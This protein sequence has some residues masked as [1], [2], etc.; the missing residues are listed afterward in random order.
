MFGSHCATMRST[1][2]TINSQDLYQSKACNELIAAMPLKQTYCCIDGAVGFERLLLIEI[3]YFRL[4]SSSKLYY[5]R[6][7]LIALHLRQSLYSL[8]YASALLFVTG[9]FALK[10]VPDLTDLRWHGRRDSWILIF[11]YRFPFFIDGLRK[12]LIT[13]PSVLLLTFLYP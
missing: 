1:T 4:K 10:L 5:L 6:P 8:R 11:W 9:A 13:P 2:C 7:F 3:L 12:E